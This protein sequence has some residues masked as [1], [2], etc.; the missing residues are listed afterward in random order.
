MDKLTICT[1][2]W[3]T[4]YPNYYVE[5]L[6]NA[7]ARHVHQEYHWAVF[8]PTNEDLHLTEIPGCF[9]RLRMFDK[10][11]QEEHHIS[12]RLVC[13]DLD[14]VVVGPLDSLFDRDESFVILHGG[15]SENP[16]PYNGSLQ[17]LRAGTHH[18]VWEDFS[19][20]EAKAKTAVYSFPDDQGWYAYKIPDAAGWKVGQDGV[21]C[22][23]KPGWPKNNE[24][25]RD[26]RIVA[27]P[28]WR[29]PSKFTH[30][31]WIKDNWK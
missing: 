26:A 24:L 12:G 4:K 25:P 28:G 1:W 8:S 10:E 3:G 2:V 19:V 16:C 15:N 21:Y 9:A 27:F 31:Q 6:K 14:A 30:L 13:L 23:Q 7:V 18:D 22:F 29:D 5:R 17:M 11:W 20:E